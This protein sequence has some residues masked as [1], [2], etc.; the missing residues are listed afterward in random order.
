[1][2][3]SNS[4]QEQNSPAVKFT[5]AEWKAKLS[6]EEYRVLRE[7]GTEQPYKGKYNEHDETG[8]YKCAGCGQALYE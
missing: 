4:K 1:M 3:S 8:T 6:P 7:K 2:S 5:E